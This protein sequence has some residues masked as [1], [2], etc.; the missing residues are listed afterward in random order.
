MENVGQRIQR[1][2]KEMGF[3]RQDDL[4]TL[5][6][7]VGQSTLSDIESKNK[8]FSALA[9]LQFSK[10]LMVSPEYIVYGGEREDMGTIEIAQLFKSLAPQEREMLLITARAFSANAAKSKAA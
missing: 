2:R 7:E 3:V 8:S 6:P 4:C 1:L 5:V 9:L 10:A